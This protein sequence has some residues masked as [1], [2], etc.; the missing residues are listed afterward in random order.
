MRAGGP[1]P[2]SEKGQKRRWGGGVKIYGK[3][4]SF[5]STFTAFNDI[6]YQ[7]ELEP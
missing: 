6:V 2:V 1:L 4:T 3:F 5:N 7:E